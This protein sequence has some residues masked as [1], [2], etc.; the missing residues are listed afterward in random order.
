M[1]AGLGVSRMRRVLITP[2][3][4]VVVSEWPASERLLDRSEMPIFTTE[5]FCCFMEGMPHVIA[6]WDGGLYGTVAVPVSM[7]ICN[8]ARLVTVL[9]V[10][11]KAIISL[12]SPGLLLPLRLPVIW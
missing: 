1:M 9:L 6:A 3:L 4:T 5:T 10:R 2:R 11:G 8:V 12:V 7:V